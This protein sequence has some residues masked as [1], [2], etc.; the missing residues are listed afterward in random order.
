MHYTL[1]I[2]CGYYVRRLHSLGNGVFIVTLLAANDLCQND[3]K[4][5]MPTSDCTVVRE[6]RHT[7]FYTSFTNLRL[8]AKDE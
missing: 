4:N 5:E 7:F 6:D 8:S 1:L 3:D 2:S